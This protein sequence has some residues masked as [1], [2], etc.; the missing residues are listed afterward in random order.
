[1]AVLFPLS[2]SFSW[3]DQRSKRVCEDDNENKQLTLCMR[4]ANLFVTKRCRIS[5]VRQ[6]DR[7][8]G[9][10][11]AHSKFGGSKCFNLISNFNTK[12]LSTPDFVSHVFS[13][14]MTAAFF[15]FKNVKPSCKRTQRCWILNVASVCT[16]CWV[17]LRVVAQSLKP[18]GLLATCKR[19][20]QLP[21]SLGQK[22]WELLR[23]FAHYCQHGRNNSHYCWPNNVGSCCVRLHI[24]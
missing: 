7:T 24:A 3:C 20:Q 13:L 17:L 4:R 23:P 22:C 21:T 15:F 16:P 2:L 12:E 8:L 1:M 10:R 14:K 5:I 6:L 9:R 18:I 19:T 11:R